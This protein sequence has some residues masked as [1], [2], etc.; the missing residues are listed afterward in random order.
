MAIRMRKHCTT[1]QP[2]KIFPKR[3]DAPCPYSNRQPRPR[4]SKTNATADL[5]ACNGTSAILGQHKARPDRDDSERTRSVTT[6]SVPLS[7]DAENAFITGNKTPPFIIVWMYNTNGTADVSPYNGISAI[8]GQ[9]KACAQIA[10]IMN[11]R[12]LSPPPPFGLRSLYTHTSYHLT[13]HTAPMVHRSHKLAVIFVLFWL[14]PSPFSQMNLVEYDC[15]EQFLEC[16][17]NWRR[18]GALGNTCYCRSPRAKTPRPSCTPL[19][20]RFLAAR[21]RKFSPPRQPGKIL[22]REN[23]PGP[24]AHCAHAASPKRAPM[25]N[26]EASA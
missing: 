5:S 7:H 2:C 10:I 23:A 22:P 25:T 4:R 6:P 21:M 14:P 13:W 20:S 1:W 26:C 9:H 15:A 24:R 18:L 16:L 19:R 11:G 3:G 12:G 8:L 17:P